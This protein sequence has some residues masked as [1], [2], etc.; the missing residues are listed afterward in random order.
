M[1]KFVH[2]AYDHMVVTQNQKAPIS[3]KTK[4]MLLEN[5]IKGGSFL[6]H[7][8]VGSVLKVWRCVKFVHLELIYS[9]HFN[10]LLN[11]NMPIINFDGCVCDALT[12]A[13]HLNL[14]AK[15]GQL[16]SLDTIK[17]SQFSG[18]RVVV[19]SQCKVA[20]HNQALCKNSLL[21]L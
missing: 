4:E 14:Y 16:K 1:N 12:C 8:Y 19:C 11:H 2:L 18:K 6:V 20:G 3:P 7:P 9:K 15:H 17:Q 5:I 21:L 10:S 13:F